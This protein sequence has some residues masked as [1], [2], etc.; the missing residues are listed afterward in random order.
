MGEKS[1]KEKYPLKDRLAEAT[2]IR[3]KY[4]ERV[5]IIVERYNI[6]DDIPNI[7]KHK[8]LVPMDITVGKFIYII[9]K[10]IKLAPEKA[11]FIFVNNKIP[12]TSMTIGTI[13]DVEQEE[14]KFLYFY[15]QSESTFGD[16][17]I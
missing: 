11:I 4:P 15:Y 14:D 8:Y 5:P 3:E 7:D 2:R 6:N 12:S 16:G 10:R 1:F 13:D 17:F 9:R